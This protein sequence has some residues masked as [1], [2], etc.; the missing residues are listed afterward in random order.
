MLSTDKNL[1]EMYAEAEHERVVLWC[2]AEHNYR[3]IIAIHSTALGPA[4]GG[5][6]FWKY[7]GD[8]AASVDALR[9]SK[10]MS[11]KNALAGLPFG[12]GK[13]IIIRDKGPFN[14][15]QLFRAH[16]RFIDSLGGRFITAEDVGTTPDDMT[17][18]RRETAHVVGLPGK[19]GEPSGMTAYGVLRAI[20]ACAKFRWGS[21]LL[22]G[23]TVAIQGCGNTGYQL[24]KQLHAAGAKL[25]VAD[26]DNQKVMRIVDDFAATSVPP[27]KIISVPADVFAPC[28]LGG[29]INDQTIGQLKVEIVAGSANNQLLESWHGDV[30]HELGIL[31]APDYVTNS[32][33]VINGCRELLAWDEET[34]RRKVK[35]IYDTLLAILK[36]SNDERR[37]PFRVADEIAEERLTASSTPAKNSTWPKEN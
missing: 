11:Y 8:K 6:R 35:Q 22:R 33:G 27:E 28:A 2:D 3:G 30:L 26:I 5:T 17:Y 19:S 15:E 31:Y 25:I 16:G 14:R 20:K 24:A 23:R 34:A 18:V 32:G 37:P 1:C 9:L 12:G 21:A 4:V 36:R 10:A 13:A 7:S 29:V